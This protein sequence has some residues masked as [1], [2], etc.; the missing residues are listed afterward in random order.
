M[1]TRLPASLDQELRRFFREHR[2]GPSE[3]LRR[4]VHEWWAMGN[5]PA[6]EFRDD[7]FGRR[8]ALRSGPEV[9]EVL[10]VWRDYGNDLEGL[11]DHFAGIPPEDLDQALGYYR[12]FPEPID[13][14]IEENERIARLLGEP[15]G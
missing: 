2:L 10:M 9:W 3:G 11:Y 4:V 14:L 12:H 13:Q 8:A 1:S 15:T 7:T 5:F 6:I